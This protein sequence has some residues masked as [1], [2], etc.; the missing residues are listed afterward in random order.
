MSLRLVEQR[1]LSSFKL[2]FMHN[3][4]V[5]ASG[6]NSS[7]PKP[8]HASSFHSFVFQT[9][10]MHFKDNFE[11]EFFRMSLHRFIE[12]QNH[13]HFQLS[14]KGKNCHPCSYH[15]LGNFSSSAH[16]LG[17]RFVQHSSRSF[18]LTQK[19]SLS[20]PNSKLHIYRTLK[21]SS[22]ERLEMSILYIG[23]Q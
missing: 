18:C 12:E 3:S 6:N 8:F 11:G 5:Q 20:W 17:K 4:E 22:S 23:L 15:C 10:R 9:K 21:R 7:L 1:S 16:S 2:L 19:T 14:A 13:G